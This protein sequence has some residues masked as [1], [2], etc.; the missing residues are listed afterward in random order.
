MIMNERPVAQK[1]KLCHLKDSALSMTESRGTLGFIAPIVFVFYRGFGVVST[2]SDVYS[3]GMM[4]LEMV[5]GRRNVK[6]MH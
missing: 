5:G 6:E 3:Y 2:K 1:K 4:M